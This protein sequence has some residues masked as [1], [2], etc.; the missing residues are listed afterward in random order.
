M[1]LNPFVIAIVGDKGTGKSALM[2]YMLYKDFLLGRTIISNYGLSFEHKQKMYSDLVKLP[3]FLQNA[4]VGYDEF[5]IAT[6]SRRS[7]SKSNISFTT[8][9]TQL[10]KRN[11]ILIY[12]TQMFGAMDR[13]VRDQTDIVISPIDNDGEIFIYKVMD[14]ISGDTIKYMRLNL[15]PVFDANLYDTNE[16]ILFTNE[17]ES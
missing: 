16:I 8:F 4:T 9:L 7:S 3:E 2:T 15:K 1:A 17:E 13:R 12:T 6:D 5:H 10:R 14:R 11:C